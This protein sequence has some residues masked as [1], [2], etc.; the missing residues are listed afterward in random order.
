MSIMRRMLIEQVLPCAS[1]HQAQ[2]V[3]DR[4]FEKSLILRAEVL[5][6]QKGVEQAMV[7]MEHLEDDVALIKAELRAFFGH[8]NFNLQALPR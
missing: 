2:E 4:L 1:L 8:D 5:P 3:V 6:V 7:V